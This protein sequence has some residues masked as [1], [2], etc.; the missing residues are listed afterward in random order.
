M[1][2]NKAESEHGSSNHTN[3]GNTPAELRDA[4]DDVSSSLGDFYR[5]ADAFVSEQA[6][7]RPHVT[8]GVAAGVGFLLGGG[9]SSRLGGTLLSMGTR[10]L[11]ARFLEDWVSNDPGK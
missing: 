1:E 5:A 11:A 10:V 7:E 9:L 3:G 6:R 4:W 2:P 8:L